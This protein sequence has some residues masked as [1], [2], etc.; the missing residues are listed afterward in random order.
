TEPV[1]INVALL[2]PPAL[3][4]SGDVRTES[5]AL[6]YH[7]GAMLAATLPEHVLLYGASEAQVSGVL[8]AL[9]AAFGPPQTSRGQLAA[10][11][12]L[13]E[14]LWESMPSRAQRRLRELCDDPS[15]I[16]YEIALGGARQAVRRAGLFV[17]GDLTVAVRE[18][19]SDLGVSTWGLDAPG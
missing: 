7:L 3:L 5:P 19:C 16:E 2:H 11:A 8:R 9:V 17:S 12:T 10:I 18:T 1:S 15:R 6:A 14:M 4:L 13:A